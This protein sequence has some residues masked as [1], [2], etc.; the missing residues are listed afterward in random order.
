MLYGNFAVAYGD[1]EMFLQV[2]KIGKVNV[3]PIIVAK[4]C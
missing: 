2:F 1:E 4:E 3:V